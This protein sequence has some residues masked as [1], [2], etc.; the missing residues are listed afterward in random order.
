MLG[1]GGVN[2]QSSAALEGQGQ[3]QI[4]RAASANNPHCPQ[5]TCLGTESPSPCK[6]DVLCLIQPC[7][8]LTEECHT[9]ASPGRG[10]RQEDPS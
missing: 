5:N 7:T 3:R 1:G 6:K 10:M 2:A 9:Y 8:L 4:E